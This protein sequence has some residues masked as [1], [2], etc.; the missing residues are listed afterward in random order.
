LS[1]ARLG[2]KGSCVFSPAR[3]SALSSTTDRER[4]RAERRQAVVRAVGRQLRLVGVVML[5]LLVVAASPTLFGFLVL[6]WLAR[7]SS[8]CSV[9]CKLD[10]PKDYASWVKARANRKG[11]N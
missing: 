4:Q 6:G 8:D 9:W 3:R 2:V 1:E 7:A 10:V 5:G 11:K